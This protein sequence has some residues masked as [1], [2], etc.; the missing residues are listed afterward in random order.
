MTA[1]KFIRLN[2]IEDNRDQDRWP[3]YFG[4][5]NGFQGK[6]KINKLYLIVAFAYRA[7]LILL[8]S[9]DTCFTSSVF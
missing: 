3:F 4:Q 2:R 8:Q 9:V 6:I 1:D 7:K 5:E